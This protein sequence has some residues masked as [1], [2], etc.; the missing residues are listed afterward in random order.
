[1]SLVDKILGTDKEKS[2]EGKQAYVNSTLSSLQVSP[3]VEVGAVGKILAAQLAGLS[4]IR[5]AVD[6]LRFH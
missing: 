5:Q 4:D 6:E 3:V 1:M 2:W